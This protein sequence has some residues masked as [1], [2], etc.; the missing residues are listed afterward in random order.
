MVLLRESDETLP[1]LRRRPRPQRIGRHRQV[2]DGPGLEVFLLHSQ[3]PASHEGAQ[4]SAERPRGRTGTRQPHAP[5][6]RPC[7]TQWTDG[8]DHRISTRLLEE[9]MPRGRLELALEKRAIS[10]R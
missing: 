2:I 6:V 4:L 10:I 1:E 3:P 7:V 9:E 5:R 8:T